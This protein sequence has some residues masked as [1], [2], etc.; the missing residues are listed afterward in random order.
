MDDIDIDMPDMQ[1]R[2]VEMC[3][4]M[5]RFMSFITWEVKATG[6]RWFR[7]LGG[8][9]LGMG[10]MVEWFHSMETMPVPGGDVMSKNLNPVQPEAQLQ[11]WEN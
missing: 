5:I 11:M 9:F 1:I 3:C 8:L 7:V 2:A 6:Q 4:L 10:M